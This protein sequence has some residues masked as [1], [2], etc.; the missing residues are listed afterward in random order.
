MN[1]HYEKENEEYN[2]AKGK[3]Q[4]GSVKVPSFANRTSKAS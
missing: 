4:G 2:K 1:D 3:T